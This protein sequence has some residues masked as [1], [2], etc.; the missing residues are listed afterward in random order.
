MKNRSVY[1]F[2]GNL[3][4]FMKNFVTDN[5]FWTNKKLIERQRVFVCHQKKLKN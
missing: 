3:C 2:T 4:Y 5:Y 1:G